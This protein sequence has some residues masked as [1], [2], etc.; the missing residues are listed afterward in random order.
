MTRVPN[1]MDFPTEEEKVM[2][3]W[4]ELDG[5]RTSLRQSKVRPRY[6]FYDGPPFATGLLHYGHILAGTI[7]VRVEGRVGRERR[8]N[9]LRR[10]RSRWYD[11][12]TVKA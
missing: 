3:L 1:R 11:F 5:F 12:E 4:K 9:M 2:R 8:K 6:T 10:K 7:K